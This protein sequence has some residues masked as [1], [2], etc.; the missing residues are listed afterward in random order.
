MKEKKTKATEG[1][2]SDPLRHQKYKRELRRH[3]LNRLGTAKSW[4]SRRGNADEKLGVVIEMYCNFVIITEQLVELHAV[5]S[6]GWARAVSRDTTRRVGKSAASFLI[7]TETCN[8][9]Q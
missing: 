1:K 7:A 2:A 8:S 4:T 6:R 5:P 3:V 9:L